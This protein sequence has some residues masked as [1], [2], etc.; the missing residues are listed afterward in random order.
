MKNI[1]L[2]IKNEF[3]LTIVSII[4]IQ[5]IK[6]LNLIHERFIIHNDNK[7]SNLCWGKFDK[8]LFTQQNFYFLIDYQYARELFKISEYECKKRLQNKMNNF[9]LW[10]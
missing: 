3:E 9:H 6:H 4:G 7:P 5:I 2:A 1:Y 8:G 10:R